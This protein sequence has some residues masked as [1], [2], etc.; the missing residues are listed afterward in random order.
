[1]AYMLLSSTTGL[2]GQ[3]DCVVTSLHVSPQPFFTVDHA[4]T[5]E[6]LVSVKR[7]EE[8]LCTN[9]AQAMDTVTEDCAELHSEPELRGVRIEVLSSQEP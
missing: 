3:P 7:M 1:M 4:A 8:F 9:E 6:A 5:S 2:I